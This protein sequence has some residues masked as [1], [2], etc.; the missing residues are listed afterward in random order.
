[1]ESGANAG[2]NNGG[3]MIAEQY[4]KNAAAMMN[5]LNGFQQRQEHEMDKFMVPMDRLQRM[6]YQSEQDR[7]TFMN[8]LDGRFKNVLGDMSFQRRMVIYGFLAGL[9]MLGFVVYG[10]YMIILRMRSKREAL[11]MKYQQEMLKMVRD[12][13]ALPGAGGLS[14]LPMG[15]QYR[16]PNNAPQFQIGGGYFNA[17]ANAN[18]GNVGGYP[19]QVVPGDGNANM[20]GTPNPS[21]MPNMGGM[22]NPA[23]NDPLFQLDQIILTGNLKERAMAAMRM[24]SLNPERALDVIQKMM[25]AE[26]SFQRENMAFSLG[27]QYHPLTL[28]LLINALTDSERRVALVAYRALKRL[29]RQPE[30]V[31]PSEARNMVLAAIKNAPADLQDKKRGGV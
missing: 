5:L 24:L 10:F 6:Y 12:M 18:A 20:G 22:P 29:E 8:Q 16:L 2:N 7:K 31:L 15:N 21:S 27:E 3:I 28:D 11:V 14:G 23:P 4:A 9:V 17:N 25:T 26:D 19:Q 1:M 30:E 13:A